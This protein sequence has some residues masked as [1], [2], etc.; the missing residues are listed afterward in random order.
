LPSIGLDGSAWGTEIAREWRMATRSEQFRANQERMHPKGVT[1]TR[2]AAAKHTPTNAQSHRT[3]HAKKKATYALE[4]AE[5]GQRATRKSTRKSANRSKPDAT[6]NILE[7][8]TKG[9]PEAR[10]RKT[11]AQSKRVRGSAGG[12]V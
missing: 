2:S 1:P 4:I 3:V 11:R 6:F 10:F 5:K 8:F 12:G 7:S 9:S